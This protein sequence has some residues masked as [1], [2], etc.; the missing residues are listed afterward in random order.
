[1]IDNEWHNPVQMYLYFSLLLDLT[2]LDLTWL[3]GSL[4]WNIGMGSPPWVLLMDAMVD[5]NNNKRSMPVRK[6]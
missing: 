6:R 1:M 4:I 5:I 3:T 2:W